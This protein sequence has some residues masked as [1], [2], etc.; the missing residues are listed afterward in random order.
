MTGAEIAQD[1]AAWG[2]E[3]CEHNIVSNLD[4]EKF[5]ERKFDVVTLRDVIEHILDLIPLLKRCYDLLRPGGYLDSA[6]C[7]ACGTDLIDAGLVL[8]EPEELQYPLCG[9]HPPI[10]ESLLI[11]L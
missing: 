10:P 11:S 5:E 8:G 1:E 6:N 9:C 4:D 2:R 3:H 7:Q